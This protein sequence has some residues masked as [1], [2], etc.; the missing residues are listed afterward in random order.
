MSLPSSMT[1][2]EL[3]PQN[4]LPSP[5]TDVA[6]TLNGPSDTG[7]FETRIQL[8]FVSHVSLS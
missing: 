6:Y 2:T 7:L 4:G 1:C 5:T 3:G 8:E